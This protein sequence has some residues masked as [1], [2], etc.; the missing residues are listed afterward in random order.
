MFAFK[1]KYFLIIES[2]KD[3]NLTDIKQY[4][5]FIIIYRRFIYDENLNDIIRFRKSCKLKFIKFYIANDIKL[6]KA[7]NSDGIYLS[8]YNK[9]FSS[10]RLKNNKFNII[11]SAHNI[12]EITLKIKQGCNYILVSKLFLVQYD[13]SAPFLGVIK[14]NKILRNISSFLVPLGGINF[15]N[16]NCLKNID[17]N[18]VALFSEIKKKPTKIIS[19]LF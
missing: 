13:K 7:V 6:S 19:R 2:I 1:K 12:K 5:K 10:L 9:K 14:F 17:C 11:G 8:S 4:N 15:E 3:I 18:A 16:L